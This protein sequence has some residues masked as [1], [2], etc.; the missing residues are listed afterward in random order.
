LIAKLMLKPANLL[1]LDEPTND[2]DLPTLNVLEDALQSFEGAV[3]LVT[4]DRYFLD[5]VA[6]ELLAFH[7]QKGEEGRVTRFADVSQWEAWQTA[8]RSARPATNSAAPKPAAPSSAPKKPKKLSFNDQRDYDTLEARILEAEARL[9]A[10]EAECARPEVVSDGARLVELT[11]QI[12][13][14]RAD[15]DRLYTRW[16]ELE[17]MLKPAD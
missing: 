15:I 1:V 11:A 4:H 6:T 14:T 8:A 10:L 13:T 16:A 9:S 3:L 12:T 2:L 7:T 5:Q 17:A